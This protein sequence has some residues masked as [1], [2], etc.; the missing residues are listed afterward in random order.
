MYS[1][2]EHIEEIRRV[3]YC[4][5]RRPYLSHRSLKATTTRLNSKD[6][7]FIIELIQ[8][9]EDNQYDEAVN[10]T[11]EFVM[12][13]DDITATGA[14]A[15]LLVFNNE[16]GFSPTN[17]D[18]ICDIHLSTKKGNRNTSYIGDKGVGFKSVFR[19]T[20]MPYIFSNGYQI[21]FN[22]EPCTNCHCGYI[23]PEW[24]ENNT[25]LDDINKIYGQDSLP[26]TIIVLPLMKPNKVAYV[27]QVISNIHP[28]VLMFLT[29]IRHLSVRIV[30]N[31]PTLGDTVYTVSVSPKINF[32][33][34]ESMNA[35]SYTLHLSA[36]KE[37]SY[38]VWR[39]KFPIM[40]ENV[41]V[42]RKADVEEQEWDVT[43]AF[44]NQDW[45][46]Y[47]D[48]LYAYFPTDML[49][50]FPFIIQADFITAPSRETILLD[51]EWNQGIL[52]CVPAAFMDAFK[53]LIVGLDGSTSSLARILGSLPF[54][55]S[56]FRRFPY[57]GEKIV[58]KLFSENIVPIE[59]YTE[60]QQFCKPGE[61]S[62]LLPEF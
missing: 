60:Q 30:T 1:P 38:S 17:I 53:T 31:D 34:M 19:V 10:P 28:E 27:K 40:S 52:E 6:S 50:N 7:R 8:N 36:D 46:R 47:S 32:R 51:K 33:T 57:L 61:V 24:V 23:V 15:T 21:R 41:V 20:P 2:K 56:P 59:T 9:A 16:N 43:L 14:Q 12:T 54:E 62:R 39:Q 58:A 3:K 37:S 22:K 25:I 13:S 35:E 11:L 5:A 42:G 55:N 18:S 26:T 48:G 49:T 4:A 45:P 29:K 44:P